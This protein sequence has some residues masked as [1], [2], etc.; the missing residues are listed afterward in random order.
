MHREFHRSSGRIFIQAS[1]GEPDSKQMH[2]LKHLRVG[3]SF[4]G[5]EILVDPALLHLVDNL[6]ERHVPTLTTVAEL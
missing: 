4:A 2:Q 6:V 5:R 1:K 3:A